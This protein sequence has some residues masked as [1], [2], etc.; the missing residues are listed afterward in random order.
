MSAPAPRLP[1]FVIGGTEKA[2]TT[3]VFDWLSGHPEVGASLRKETDFFREQYTGNRA[4]DVPRYAAYFEHADPRARVFMEASPGYLGEAALVAP[5]MRSL[6]P[7]PKL[8]FILR[9]P[10][11]RLYSS[12]HFH[13]GKLNLPQDLTFDDY[14]RRCLAYDRGTR[15]PAS[16]G[17]EEWYLKVLRFGCYADLLA[18]YRDQFPSECVKVAFFET[19]RADERRFMR[20][21]SAFL[22]IDATHWDRFDFRPSNVT[23]SARHRGLH[24]LAMRTNALAEPLMRRYPVVKQSLVRVYKALNQEREGYDPMPPATRELLIDYYAPSLRRLEQQLERPLPE[25]WRRAAQGR[26]AA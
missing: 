3:S 7:G 21:L 5:R 14:V 13:H 1:N 23:F 2:G 22:E 18:V 16:L 12:Y 25:A 8:L 24:R 17:L 11:D 9:D 26:A 4:V 19:L 20:D 6:L 15:T 10:I